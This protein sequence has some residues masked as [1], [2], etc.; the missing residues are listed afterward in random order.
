MW[1]NIGGA[2]KNENFSL[3]SILFE[4]PATDEKESSAGR[5]AACLDDWVSTSAPGGMSGVD[6]AK[7]ATRRFADIKILFTSGYT[8]DVLARHGEIDAQVELVQ[9]PFHKEELAQKLRTAMT[10]SLN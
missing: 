7:E 5:S 3:F 9:K 2:N 4:F 8:E 10:Q 1:Q 6:I